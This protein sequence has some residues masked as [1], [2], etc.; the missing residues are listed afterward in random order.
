MVVDGAVKEKLIRWEAAAMMGIV[1]NKTTT[2][3]DWLFAPQCHPLIMC[4]GK[5]WHWAPLTWKHDYRGLTGFNEEYKSNTL[6][7]LVLQRFTL[8]IR[9]VCVSGCWKLVLD[10]RFCYLCSDRPIKLIIRV[11][12]GQK[13]GH[14]KLPTQSSGSFMTDVFYTEAPDWGPQAIL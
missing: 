9:D 6:T 10:Q 4:L 11:V 1:N 13:N 7:T 12:A 8:I 2:A 14:S 3:C 5:M